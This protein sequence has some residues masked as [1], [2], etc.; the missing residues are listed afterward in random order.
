MKAF[1]KKEWM[2]WG[3][4]GRILILMFVFILFGFK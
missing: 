1:L 4:S 2:E 3:R